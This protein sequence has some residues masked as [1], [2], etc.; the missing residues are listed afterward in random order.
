MRFISVL[1]LSGLLGLGA[2]SSSP[3]EP[4]Q[5][6]SAAEQPVSANPGGVAPEG[7]PQLINSF[8]IC[9]GKQ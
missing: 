6:A 1:A 3:T 5:S 7:C 4:S 8:R 2:C 9:S